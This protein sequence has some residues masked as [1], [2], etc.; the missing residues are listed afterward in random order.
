MEIVITSTHL[1]LFDEE[2]QSVAE[3]PLVTVSPHFVWEVIQAVQ[4]GDR[5]RVEA[6]EHQEVRE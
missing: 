1:T 4:Q 5:K 2:G 3:W 6:L